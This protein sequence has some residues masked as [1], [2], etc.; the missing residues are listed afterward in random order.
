MSP[1]VLSESNN[2]R[3]GFAHPKVEPLPALT[4]LRFFAAFYVLMFHYIGSAGD[5]KIISIGY[6]G[7]TFFFILSGFILSH[8]YSNVDFAKPRVVKSYFIA[9]IARIYPVFILSLFVGLPYFV[10]QLSH[11]ASPG[12]RLLFSASAVL[13]PLGLH[14]WV[15]GAA[16]ALNCPSWSVSTELF[17]YC[18][19]PMA[20]PLIL[21]RPFIS[22]FAT[23][24]LWL[25]C[26]LAYWLLWMGVG[27]G[28]LLGGDLS[29]RLNAVSQL[30]KFFPVGRLPE[31]LLGMLLY[32]FWVR[33]RARIA[34]LVGPLFLV[35]S[36]AAVG[37]VYGSKDIP[38]VVLHNGFT[39]IV[40]APMIIAAASMR[41]CWLHR[42]SWVFLGRISYSLY[43]LHVPILW[44]VLLLDRRGFGGALTEAPL[45]RAAIACGLAIVAAAIT[46]IWVEEPGRRYVAKRLFGYLGRGS[47]GAGGSTIEVSKRRPMPRQAEQWSSN[48]P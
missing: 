1:N 40:W 41:E 38:E 23:A 7:V 30:I 31:F 5:P 20:L 12:F 32:V 22:L 17:F 2:D 11:I 27:G 9:R 39:A 14:S 45:L 34:G 6:T 21:R 13:A 3:A 8:N 47:G 10:A 28:Q 35:S 26:C 25:A 42:S 33:K 48:A 36:L 4:S 24:S 44:T 46:F 19:F 18:L 16:C 43:L 15:P 37:V 29:P